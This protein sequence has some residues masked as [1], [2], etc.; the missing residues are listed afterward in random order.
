M[1]PHDPAQPLDFF[2][3]LRN[4]ANGSREI[5]KGLKNTKRKQC[6]AE[7]E[8]DKEEQAS[9]SVAKRKK[10]KM[11]SREGKNYN[12]DNLHLKPLSQWNLCIF[13]ERT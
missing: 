7:E 13:E 1:D 9:K 3:T 10:R 6:K 4:A 5:S 12:Y 11:G 2:E 8:E